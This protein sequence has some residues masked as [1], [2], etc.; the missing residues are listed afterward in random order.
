MHL[1]GMD[2][3]GGVMLVNAGTGELREAQVVT[4]SMNILG[5]E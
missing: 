3:V 4:G 2:V 5:S 1:W